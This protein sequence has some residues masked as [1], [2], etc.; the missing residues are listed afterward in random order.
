MQR[1]INF[2][3]SPIGGKIVMALSGAMIILFLMGHVLGNLLIFSSQN[4]LNTYAYWLQNSPMLWVF[5]LTMLLLLMLHSLLAIRLFF[6]NKSARPVQYAV[7]SDLQLTLSAK[8]MIVSG[9]VIFVFIVFHII[10][11]TLGWLPSTSFEVPVG[12]KMID[13]YSNVIRGFQQPGITLFYI[14]SLLV[15]GLHLHHAF[16]SLFQTL[17]F[18]HQNFH[19]ALDLL[20]PVVIILLTLAFISIP[21]AVWFGFLSLPLP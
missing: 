14:F 18:H 6:Q 16:K 3:L 11:L 1:L 7:D 20:A 19:Q 15:I 8:T 17:G 2:L 4:S 21:V 12:E 5:R 13:V 10:H 9:L